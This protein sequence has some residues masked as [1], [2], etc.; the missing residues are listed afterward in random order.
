MTQLDTRSDGNIRKFVVRVATRSRLPPEVIEPFVENN[1]RLK[2][3]FREDLETLKQAVED[4][5][6]NVGSTFELDAES[7]QYILECIAKDAAR[8]AA[9]SEAAAS[10]RETAGAGVMDTLIPG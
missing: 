9:E 4:E 10:T 6:W 7:V 5:P 1:H 3:Q 8:E 2:Q